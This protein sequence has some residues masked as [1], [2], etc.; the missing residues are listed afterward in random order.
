MNGEQQYGI[1]GM[2]LPKDLQNLAKAESKKDEKAGKEKKNESKIYCVTNNH[3][4]DQY[5]DHDV[6][7]IQWN[8]IENCY[9]VLGEKEKLTLDDAK[10]YLNGLKLDKEDKDRLG[11]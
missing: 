1:P 10:K 5:N 6:L 2:E 11:L 4:S 9:V 3:T 8:E 7:F